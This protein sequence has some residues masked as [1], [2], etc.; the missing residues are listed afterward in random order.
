[1]AKYL[2]IV[3]SPNKAKSISKYLGGEYRVLP[4]LGHL[5][6]ME[7]KGG[8]GVLVEENFKLNKHVAK[9]KEQVAR[10][11]IN[12]AKAADL[13]YIA[14]DPDREGEVIADDVLQYIRKKQIKTPIKRVTYQEVTEAAI[15]KAIANAGGVNIHLANAGKTRSALD[16][17]VGFKVSPVLWKYGLAGSSAGRV[18][19]PGLRLVCERQNEID[20]FIP[21]AYYE[22][23]AMLDDKGVVLKSHFNRFKTN[24]GEKIDKENPIFKAY[25]GNIDQLTK[26]LKGIRQLKVTDITE[27][28]N[29]RTPVPPF[30]TTTL[31]Q[32][33]F[34]KLGYSPDRTMS[35]AQKLFEK[36]YITYMRTD[37]VVLSLEAIEM[38]RREI[39]KRYGKDYLPSEKRVYA[40][41]GKNAQE[42]HEAIRPTYFG[43]KPSS[44]T[45]GLD[46]DENKLFRLIEARTYAS[47]M[48]DSKS[49]TTTI[50]LDSL[51]GVFGFKISGTRVL[52]DGFTRAYATDEKEDNSNLPDLK[53]GTII[54]IT[55]IIREDK[56]TE[57]PARYNEASLVKALE[58][59]GIGRPSTYASIIKT[60]KDRQ[61]VE[62]DGKALKVTDKGRQVNK[63]LTEKLPDYVDY[64]FTANMEDKLDNIAHGKSEMLDTLRVFHDKL[65]GDLKP[66]NEGA[67]EKGHADFRVLETLDKPCPECGKPLVKRLGK[68][69]AY[70]AC[71]GYPECKYIEKANQELVEGRLCPKCSSKLYK[72]VSRKG[73][74]YI[75]CSAYPKCDF[76]EWIDDTPE[77]ERVAC[78]YCGIGHL[79]QRKGR[80]GVFYTCTNYPNCRPHFISEGEYQTLKSGGEIF[81]RS[82]EERMRYAKKDNN[83]KKGKGF[84]GK[85][86]AK[87]AGKAKKGR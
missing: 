4:T 52:F 71:S 35:I 78:P 8:Q 7:R 76:V 87:K 58:K 18:Q 83:N 65:K 5:F 51:D 50:V 55:E 81:L 59:K 42:A 43:E 53:V 82:E 33:A 54:D 60:L 73:T 48:S 6:A 12:A 29:T 38:I 66:L 15:K 74:P 23:N 40:N 80:Y 37:S 49:L 32:A 14:S 39:P 28:N 64:N 24:K 77:S 13:I 41:K 72:K 11:I 34:T 56:A 17:L 27:R 69:G 26:D 62:R 79:S 45:S 9:G 10:E 3:E 36:G 19:S 31:Q 1:M 16:Y 63:F 85:P 46:D 20:T 75:S 47:Q 2:F 61:Y 25:N 67:K 70:V 30:I 21:E 86:N 57:P 84:K 68:Y 22:F 44:I